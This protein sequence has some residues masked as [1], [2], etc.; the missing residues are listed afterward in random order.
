MKIKTH[1]LFLGLQRPVPLQK[2]PEAC[3]DTEQ[4]IQ[5]MAI[6]RRKEREKRL[7]EGN[8]DNKTEKK[9]TK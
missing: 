1:H 5:I 7:T 3:H 9:Q 4:Q 8:E 2:A 6:S